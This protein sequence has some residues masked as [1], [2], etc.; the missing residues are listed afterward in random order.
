M[1]T[2][3]TTIIAASL[4]SV[5]VGAALALGSSN[6]QGDSSAGEQS[7]GNGGDHATG[8]ESG[9]NG[10]GEFH[11]F[12]FSLISDLA[13]TVGEGSPPPGDDPNDPSGAST[14]AG[15]PHSFTFFDYGAHL[16]LAVSSK[17]ITSYKHGGGGSPPPPPPPPPPPSGTSVNDDNSG[18]APPIFGPITFLVLISYLLCQ[19]ALDNQKEFESSQKETSSSSANGTATNDSSLGSSSFSS[20]ILGLGNDSFP[21]I[22]DI[23]EPMLDSF[24]DFFGNE[25]VHFAS[26]NIAP[27]LE[28][29]LSP[30]PTPVTFEFWD[31]DAAGR[32][33]VSLYEPMPT[34]PN[35]LPFL[36]VT[37]CSVD[38]KPP[39]RSISTLL[40]IVAALHTLFTVFLCGIVVYLLS[41]VTFSGFGNDAAPED[42][43]EVEVSL[44]SLQL[45]VYVFF[46]HYRSTIVL[47]AQTHSRPSGGPC[48]LSTC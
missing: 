35:V 29:A 44:I 33:P 26:S 9:Q 21:L 38:D 20:G 37:T 17:L 45:H 46:S 6:G 13:F 16:S 39:S 43:D 48:H 32:V 27:T 24:E 30:S 10:L 34:S 8:G 28:I 14:G 5:G 1:S 40:R 23:L 36:E 11:P 15:M 2:G 42:M 3:K 18:P 31:A 47:S 41:Y 25:S 19:R 7:S 4:V 12:S 22:V